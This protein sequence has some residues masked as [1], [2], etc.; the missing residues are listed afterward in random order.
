MARRR[1]GAKSPAT[2]TAGLAARGRDPAGDTSL[3]EPL[4]PKQE[5]GKAE[6]AAQSQS[7]PAYEPQHFQTSLGEQMRAQQQA[8]EQAQ[9]HGYIDNIPNLSPATRHWLHSNPF[10]V[11]RFD[12]LN[13][14]HVIA[15]EQRGIRPDTREY[16]YF[17]S[18]MLNTYG[19]LPPQQPMQA[20]PAPPP[21][22]PPPMPEPMTPMTHINIESESSEHEPEHEHMAAITSAPVSRSDSGHSIEPEALLPSQVKLTPLQREIANGPGGCGEIEYA[23]QLLKLQKL[24]KAKVHE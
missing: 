17:L 8:A 12:L 21:P 11:F 19:H 6:P 15:T 24:Q 10:G 3:Q 23:K 13:G 18:A 14:A 9:L 1:Y 5:Y 22:M 7:E 16:F 20:T 4:A 2:S